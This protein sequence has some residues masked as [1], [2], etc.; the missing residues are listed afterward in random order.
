MHSNPL[1]P[2]LG[3]SHW[4]SETIG[5]ELASIKDVYNLFSQKLMV[6]SDFFLHYNIVKSLLPF[7]SSCQTLTSMPP[8]SLPNTWLFLISYCYKYLFLNITCSVCIILLVYMSSEMTIWYWITDWCDLP[9]GRLFLPLS[10][11]LS[12]LWFFV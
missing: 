1:L 5:G 10:S 3:L 9:G 4:L 2:V 11:F 6:I 7:L 8:C 12:Y